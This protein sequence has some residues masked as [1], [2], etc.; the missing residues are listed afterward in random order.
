MQL[1]VGSVSGIAR[2]GGGC[3]MSTRV[4]GQETE[5]VLMALEGRPRSQPSGGNGNYNITLQQAVGYYCEG[6]LLRLSNKTNASTIMG[7]W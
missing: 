4:V 2:G 7:F 5:R 1:V 6:V 3:L